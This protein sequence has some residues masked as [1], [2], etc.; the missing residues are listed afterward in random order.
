M[1]ITTT[2]IIFV[3]LALALVFPACN[4]SGGGDDDGAA[5]TDADTDTDSDADTDADTDADSD[6][7]TDADTDA[8]SDADT[9]TGTGE[10]ET[11]T[12]EIVNV[13]G[14]VRYFEWGISMPEHFPGSR[15][16]E[17]ERSIDGGASWQPCLIELPGC[18]TELCSNFEPGEE[19]FTECEPSTLIKELQPGAS[20][21]ISWPVDVP[22][23]VP[24]YCMA[25]AGT[26]YEFVAA[27]AGL[28]R[29]SFVVATEIFCGPQPCEP[30]PDGFY[31]DEVL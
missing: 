5:G 8:D 14:A 16:F 9:D 31:F 23:E 7:D 21:A 20:V 13:A 17:C 10:G 28:Y 19:C 22:A 30:D 2:A 11:I 1:R 12:I 26:C 18:G 6:A 15:V 24:G 27:A 25:E 4:S 3:A 29:F